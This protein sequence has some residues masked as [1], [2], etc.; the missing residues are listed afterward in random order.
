[1]D[2]V[3]GAASQP[4][5]PDGAGATSAG[6]DPPPERCEDGPASAR[7]A[8]RCE[9]ERFNSRLRV[10]DRLS[11]AALALGLVVAIVDAAQ[12]PEPKHVL[13]VG[14]FAACLCAFALLRHRAL[15][16]Q[17][18]TLT[19]AHRQI[20]EAEARDDRAMR[21]L[22][23]LLGLCAATT[24]PDLIESLAHKLTRCCGVDFAAISEVDRHRDAD[25]SPCASA[26]TVAFVSGTSQLDPYAFQLDDA[27][28]G[29]AFR[30]GFTHR[31]GDVA[32]RFPRQRFLRNERIESYMGIA[33]NDSQG[34]PIGIIGLYSRSPLPDPRQTERALRAIAGRVGAE[35]ERA[36][37][38]RSL[39][40][41][42]ARLNAMIANSPGVAVQW[43]DR[44]GRILLWNRAS[45][46]MYGFTAEEAIGRDL[47]ELIEAKCGHERFRDAIPH[48][49][50]SGD[51]LGPAEF[52][53]RR[54]SGELGQCISTA[55]A[56]PGEASEPCIACMDVDVTQLRRAES[57]ARQA[58]K[59]QAIGQLAG[60]VAHDFNNLLVLINGYA[61]LL[62]SELGSAA[63]PLPPERQAA[64]RHWIEGILDSGRRA[65]S[66]TGQLLTIGRKQ[67][68]APRVVDVHRELNALE[69]VL[70]ELAT[71][72]VPLRLERLARNATIRV[73]PAQLHQILMNL[74]VNARDALAG[75][76]D[77]P[78]TAIV[79]RTENVNHAADVRVE[80]GRPKGFRLSVIDDGVG[81]TP[82][83]QERMFEPFFTTKPLGEGTGLGMA[84]V[85]GATQ[86]SGGRISV[87]S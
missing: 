56:I 72:F 32:A 67:A 19:S 24:G 23:E 41:S 27:P 77:A 7:D 42:E 20:A 69:R 86:E 26:R 68:L 58:Q 85:Y 9:L 55:F 17:R 51:P 62:A 12:D 66:L 16:A 52:S 44:E 49:L 43:C 14:M 60:G 37:I 59:L 4:T 57:A 30:L 38:E 61:E 65:A 75:R 36:A 29:E 48:V 46:A 39:R 81:M 84:T 25:A 10:F 15:S 54:K 5:T 45:E 6:R 3:E 8:W 11:I 34:R 28:C 53:F 73:D 70:N 50:T 82:E 63:N 74:I 13:F 18:R 47:E 21:T 22:D 64:Q 2:G 83:V 1:M 87:Q 71:P 35:L 80:A 76:G 31:S 40:E 78:R 33:L 79:V